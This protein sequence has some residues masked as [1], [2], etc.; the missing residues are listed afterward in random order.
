MK[1]DW[2]ELETEKSVLQ[3][4]KKSKFEYPNQENRY[5]AFS[6]EYREWS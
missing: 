4:V 3:R 6:R 5:V 2:G 1:E